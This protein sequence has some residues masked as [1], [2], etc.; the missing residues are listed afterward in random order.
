MREILF[1]GK[2]IDGKWVEGCC[3]VDE[4]DTNKV[5]IG[6]IF[7]SEG[8]Q[9][10]DVDVA[11]VDP[12]TVCQY[13]GYK[14]DTGKRIFEGD[15]V[16]F[17]DMTSTESGYSEMSCCGQVGYDEEEACFYVT[18]RLS[19]ESWEVLGEC[20]IIGNIFDNPELIGE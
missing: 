14:D 12:K 20:H 15:I 19:A 8:R 6:Y 1:R 5:Y 10:H 9:P 11:L 4:M 18:D 16:G 3:V 2:D 7:G 17:E 13:T